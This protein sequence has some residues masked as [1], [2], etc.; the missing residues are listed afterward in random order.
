MVSG[1]ECV[2]S[3]LG[4]DEEIRLSSEAVGRQ[5]AREVIYDTLGRFLPP[6]KQGRENVVPPLTLGYAVEAIANTVRAPS[7]H[8]TTGET[9]LAILRVVL[10]A[11][12][13]FFVWCAFG[14][15]AS[16]V[17]QLR[18]DRPISDLRHII[19]TSR[20]Q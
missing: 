12:A 15:L 2:D 13:L 8:D 20:L 4:V 9:M 19:M 16:V 17:F 14:F 10:G 6:C 11:I 1:V 3:E 18:I 7:A 5:C